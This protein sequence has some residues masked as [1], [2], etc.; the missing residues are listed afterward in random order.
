VSTNSKKG[1]AHA[2]T[3]FYKILYRGVF[4]KCAEISPARLWGNV[5]D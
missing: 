5:E 2:P 4:L 3:G 1:L